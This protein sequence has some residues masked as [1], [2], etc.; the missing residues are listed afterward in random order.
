MVKFKFLEHRADVYVVAYGSTLEEAFENAAL[1][2]FEVMTKTL[3]VSSTVEEAVE[4]EGYDE[5]SLLYN[6]IETLLVRFELTERLYSQFK[7]ESIK[8]MGE[9]FNLKAKISGER[10]NQEKHLQKVGVKAVTYHRME[11][12]REEDEVVVKFILDI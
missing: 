5:K 3:N 7:V 11:I 9:M 4:V 8:K 2:T 6:W 1:A 10:F 12:L